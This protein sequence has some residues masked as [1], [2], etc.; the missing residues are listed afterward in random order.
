M[1]LFY[2]VGLFNMT[3]AYEFD[4]RR[5]SRRYLRAGLLPCRR[6]LQAH[7]QRGTSSAPQEGFPPRIGGDAAMVGGEARGLL[8]GGANGLKFLS[9]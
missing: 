1:Y 3:S 6:G 2:D 9:Y 8:A 7:F 5:P 4:V